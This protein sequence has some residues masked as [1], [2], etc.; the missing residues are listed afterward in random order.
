M[1][2]THGATWETCLSKDC[3]RQKELMDQK[4]PYQQL[5]IRKG[6]VNGKG[7]TKEITKIE[8]RD[9]R[10]EDNREM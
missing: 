1:S 7:R 10:R 8:L 5:N 6:T 3:Q 4:M 9:K 2:T